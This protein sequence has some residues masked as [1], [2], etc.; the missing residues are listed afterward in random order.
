MWDSVSRWDWVSNGEHVRGLAKPRPRHHLPPPTLISTSVS[1]FHNPSPLHRDDDNA[2]MMKRW[3]CWWWGNGQGRTLISCHQRITPP[4]C[5]PFITNQWSSFQ[6]IVIITPIRQWT[7]L[8][9][10]IGL[11]A[12]FDISNVLIWSLQELASEVK[13]ITKT[14]NH[15]FSRI[16]CHKIEIT[17]H[18]VHINLR[19]V[20]KRSLRYMMNR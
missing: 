4:A 2:L 18:S 9:L 3:Q 8:K 16:I 6:L 12:D 1:Q 10:L 14:G 17:Y 11:F 7:V 13:L 5:S 20:D 19:V 15:G